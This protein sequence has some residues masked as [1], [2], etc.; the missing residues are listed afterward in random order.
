MI[1]T[2]THK[3]LE[4]TSEFKIVAK[5]KC[6]QQGMSRNENMKK[7]LY[8]SIKKDKILMTEFFKR[9]ENLVLLKA[10]KHCWNKLGRT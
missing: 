10:T 3:L 9:D 6:N 5:H 4:C 8:N 7:P 1:Y 2:H